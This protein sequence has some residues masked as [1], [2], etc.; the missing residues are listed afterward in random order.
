M[1]ATDFLNSVGLAKLWERIGFWFLTKASASKTYVR[2]EDVAT[3]NGA[4]L[5]HGG[6]VSVLAIDTDTL[7]IDASVN[8]DSPN[9]VSGDA[10][11]NYCH[12]SV[13]GFDGGFY[14]S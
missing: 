7:T 13:D 9:P 11:Y 12:E 3:V 4:S 14:V 6:N 5:V 10:V 8:E 1:T 2:I